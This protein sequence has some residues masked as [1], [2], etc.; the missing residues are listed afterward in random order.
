M[1][2]VR[3]VPRK[4]DLSPEAILAASARM[5]KPTRTAIK[6]VRDLFDLIDAQPTTYTD[7]VSRA[8]IAY[9]T[10]ERWKAGDHSPRLSDFEAI[11]GAAG[12]ELRIVVKEEGK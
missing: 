12:L 3:E 4:G 8:G 10:L 5:K 7:I 11:L 9:V 6:V 1:P 2:R